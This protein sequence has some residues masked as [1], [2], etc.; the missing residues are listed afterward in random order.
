[1]PKQ[2]K[3]VKSQPQKTTASSLKPEAKLPPTNDASSRP[4]KVAD[5]HNIMGPAKAALEGTAR[6]LAIE[7]GTRQ[8]R[9]NAISPGPLQTRA[10]LGIGHFDTL[11]VA[12]R[13]RAPQ[14]CRVTIEDV[15]A[16]AVMLASDGAKRVSGDI[17]Y[18]HG[19]LHV[20]A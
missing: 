13:M 11:I 12:A 8:I 3:M 5:H 15:G 6:A 4:E 20:S 18:I 2:V 1:M 19:G 17:S 14:Q 16:M 10:G 9:V 7:L